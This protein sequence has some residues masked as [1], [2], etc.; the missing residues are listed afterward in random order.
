MFKRLALIGLDVDDGANGLR[1]GLCF[2]QR[3]GQEEAGLFPHFDNTTIVEFT[4]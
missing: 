3:V 2:G 1:L 4:K